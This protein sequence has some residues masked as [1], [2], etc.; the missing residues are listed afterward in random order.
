MATTQ[1]PSVLALS[2]DLADA[3]AAL[4]PSLVRIPGRRGSATGIAW[5]PRQVVTTARAL[6]RRESVTVVL[7]D[8]SET[9][10]T[11]TGRDWG[12]DLG[13]V[14]LPDSAPELAVPAWAEEPGLRVGNLVLVLGR[15]GRQ[16]RA[17]LGLVSAV[18]GAWLAHGAH[19]ISAYVDVDASLP[20]GF[21][22][23]PLVS[24]AGKV[25]GLNSRRLVPGGTTLPTATIRRVAADLEAHGGV[26]RAWLGVA[27]QG[28]GLPAEAG[29]D[30]GV[31]VTAVEADSPAAEAGVVLGD[32]L[33]AIGEE[34]LAGPEDLLTA[35]A[36][37]G[38]GDEITL[39]IW[40]AGAETTVA[41]TLGERPARKHRRRCG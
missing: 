4:E 25:V 31:L 23:G 21:A 19:A 13:L 24:A 18:G 36:A 17:T 2:S 29:Q 26:R 30:R 9:T 22:G 14:T 33:L 38:T 35:L 1:T 37:Q 27:V 6:G 5:S 20:G 3:V 12:T 28:A 11:V 8:G 7:P 40:R 34:V 41:V 16:V 39:R 32:T 10:G 15:P